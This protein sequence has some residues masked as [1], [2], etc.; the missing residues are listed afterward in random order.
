[1]VT[2][3]LS[4]GADSAA[5]RG[6]FAEKVGLPPDM[7]ANAMLAALKLMMTYEEYLTAVGRKVSEKN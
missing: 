1:M 2:F 3:K 7:T 6:E 4:G 5:R